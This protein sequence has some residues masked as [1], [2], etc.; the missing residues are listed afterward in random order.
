M[1]AGYGRRCRECEGRERA[2]R[3]I[4]ELTAAL[5]PPR[6]AARFASFGEWLVEQVDPEKAA[7]NAPPS[8]AFFN[9][10]GETWDDVPDYGALVAHFGAEGLR[11]QRRVMRWLADQGLIAI[12]P[13]AR[14][15]DSERRRIAATTKRL[16][17]GS[18]V[19]NI[20]NEYH[21]ALDERVEAGT[22]SL[23]SMRLALA[24]AATLLEAAHAAGND[25]PTQETLDRLMRRVPGQRAALTGFV[26]W[27]RD[28][29]GIAIALPPKSKATPRKRRQAARAEMLSLLRE[30]ANGNELAERWRTAALV[31]FHD[32]T[33]KLARGVKEA[34]VETDRD[35][36]RITI[37]GDGY[38][39]P[40]APALAEETVSRS[41]P[42]RPLEGVPRLTPAANPQAGV[43][44]RPPSSEPP[45]STA[46]RTQSCDHP[47]RESR[48]RT[49]RR[50]TCTGRPLGTKRC[51]VTGTPPRRFLDSAS[52]RP[53]AND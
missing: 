5:K 20:L 1:P 12:D 2:R 21:A 36:L 26:R 16:P 39:I 11:R 15:D 29:Q 28:T 47:C 19:A 31:Y 30:E 46:G 13:R 37:N 45:G 35:G 18:K 38:W 43:S 49:G 14:E 44:G 34:D 53:R 40:N 3:Q 52:S 25:L 51:D 6:I 17:A 50:S 7:R 41:R 33:P 22:L 4:G 9:E 48:P 24:L 23:R 10:I 27:L 8:A 42:P 32:V